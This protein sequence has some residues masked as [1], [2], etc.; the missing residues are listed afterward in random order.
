[1]VHGLQVS[2][3]GSVADDV[4]GMQVSGIVN[5]SASIAGL[6]LA[7]LVNHTG[8][9]TGVQIG[10]INISDSVNGGVP[11]GLL[12][13]S[14]HG[15]KTVD[16]SI[17]EIFPATVSFKTGVDGFYNILTASSNFDSETHLWSFGY[18]VGSR[19]HISKKTLFEFEAIVSH[20]NRNQFEEDVNLLGRFNM[21][22]AVQF[23]K[24]GEVYAGPSLNFYAT[25]VYN[26]DSDQYGYSIA[27]GN[28]LYEELIFDF[29]KP[30]F[31]QAW[32]G[33]QAGIRL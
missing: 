31:L 28:V 11:I 32:I 19:F 7:G 9:L 8:L 16:V 22:F 14:K 5:N 13:F 18:G 2:G 25:Q 3:L 12:S 29:D 21:N 6:Q 27:P 23:G 24:Y 26:A 17:N 4:T 1:M 30:T 10:L 33:F 15:Y 20:L